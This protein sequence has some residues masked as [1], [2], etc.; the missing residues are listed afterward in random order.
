[1]H[2]LRPRIMPWGSPL[3]N[4]NKEYGINILMSKNAHAYV[5]GYEVARRIDAIRVVGVQEP[6]LV[7]ELLCSRRE[8]MAY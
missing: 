6:A 2:A 8:D 7:C 4:A 1:M 3:Q 5:A